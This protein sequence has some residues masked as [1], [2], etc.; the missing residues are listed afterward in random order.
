MNKYF[1]VTDGIFTYY[2]NVVD[3]HIKWQLS[4]FDEVVPRDYNACA[5]LN[6]FNSRKEVAKA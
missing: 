5:L 3:G 6:Y 1:K 2:E 4:E